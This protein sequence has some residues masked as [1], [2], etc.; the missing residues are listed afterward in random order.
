MSNK[1]K[2]YLKEQETKF[3]EIS[4]LSLSDFIYATKLFIKW[5]EDILKRF[6]CYTNENI[7]ILIADFIEEKEMEFNNLLSNVPEYYHYMNA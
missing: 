1:D 7:N 5:K 2:S 3:L 6:S 4:N